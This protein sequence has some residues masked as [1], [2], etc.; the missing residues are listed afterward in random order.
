SLR[1]ADIEAA[2]VPA[3]IDEIPI[4]ALAAT[5]AEG[6]SRFK[7]LAELRVKESDRLSH[8]ARILRA[9]GAKAAV[10]GDDLIVEGPTPLHAARVDPKKDHRLA[11]TAL[12][13]GLLCEEETSVK[14]GDCIAIS[15]PSFYEDL[16]QAR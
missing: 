6:A 8:I 14:D 10:E 5:Q 13:A 9:F 11:M 7:G 4:L 16:K 12:V 1:A 3:L 2:E 15:Y